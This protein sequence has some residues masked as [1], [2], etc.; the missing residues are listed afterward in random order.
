MLFYKKMI[1]KIPIT[2]FRK[3]WIEDVS[4]MKMAKLGWNHQSLR[5]V[6]KSSA[7]IFSKRTTQEVLESHA[8][9]WEKGLL[10]SVTCY[11]MIEGFVWFLV[12]DERREKVYRQPGMKKHFN[13]FAVQCLGPFAFLSFLLR[14]HPFCLHLPAFLSKLQSC[15]R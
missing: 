11:R 3:E 10:C 1:H 8:W 4:V 2:V 7:H 14:F 5:L 12:M 6:C 13:Q 9:E 15:S